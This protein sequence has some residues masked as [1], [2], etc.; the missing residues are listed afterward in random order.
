MS[1]GAMD[2]VA[3]AAAACRRCSSWTRHAATGVPRL[4]PAVLRTSRQ[5]S[6]DC[7]TPPCIALA[8]VGRQLAHA[9]SSMPSLCFKRCENP[10]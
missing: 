2:R 1:A 6:N 3:H 7:V 9:A 4:V 8:W 10:T 5:E